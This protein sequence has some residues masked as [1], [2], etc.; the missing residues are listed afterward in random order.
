MPRHAC[1]LL[2]LILLQPL[3][4]WLLSRTSFFQLYDCS[5]EASVPC[6]NN[7]RTVKYA[8]AASGKSARGGFHTPHHPCCLL[9]LFLMQPLLLWLCRRFLECADFRVKLA[10]FH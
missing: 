4:L 9:S 7:G 6:G 2:S 10:G 8:V 3:L 5:L 1:G